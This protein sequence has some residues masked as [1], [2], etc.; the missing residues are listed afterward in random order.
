MHPYFESENASGPEKQFAEFLN[1]TLANVEWFFRN[2]ESDSAYFAV[3]IT[4][5]VGEISPFF[6]DWIVRFSDGK[7]GL[8][9]TK[10]GITA[11]TAK[12]RADGLAAYIKSEKAKG[13]SL[14][15][16]IVVPKDGSWRYNDNE[17]YQ[18]EPTLKDWK[19]LQ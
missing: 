5:D 7:I 15:G 18:Y 17:N 16:G 2:G 11:A 12:S 9:D 14:F 10:S 3:P 1:N 6:V 19:F 13:K 4:N 8:F